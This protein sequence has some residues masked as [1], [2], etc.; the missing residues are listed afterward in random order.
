MAKLVM[1]VDDFDQETPASETVVFVMDD[2]AYSLDLSA[3]NAKAL[4]DQLQPWMDVAS[5]LGRHKV[6]SAELGSSSSRRLKTDSRWYRFDPNDSADVKRRKKQY[7]DAARQFGLDN[8]YSLG[9]R[10]V[11]PDEVYREYDRSLHARGLASGPGS[12]GL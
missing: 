7:R 11:V 6:S 12:V 3:D 10:G 9:E 2:M 8:G 4:R 5:R 1:L